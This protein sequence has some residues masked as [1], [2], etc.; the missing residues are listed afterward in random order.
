MVHVLQPKC[1]AAKPC[2][3]IEDQT[4]L[5]ER[6][7]ALFSDESRIKAEP[8]PLFF[9]RD[10]EEIAWAFQEA[11]KHNWRVTLSAG[12]TGIAAGAVPLKSDALLSLEKCLF[13]PSLFCDSEVWIARVPVS[14]TLEGLQSFLDGE[15]KSS[16]DTIPPLWLPVDP[17]ETSA[18]VGGAVAANASGARTFAY[19]SIRPWVVGLSIVLP[20]GRLL[21][22]K[23]GECFAKDWVFGFANAN[24]VV[25]DIRLPQV[26]IPKTKHTLGYETSENMDLIDLF[27]GSEGTLGAIVS[28]DLRLDIMPVARVGITVVAPSEEKALSLVKCARESARALDKADATRKKNWLLA[29][30]EYFDPGILRFLKE[31]RDADGQG[32][33]IPLMP[34]WEGAAV[35]L[36]FHIFS[37]FPDLKEEVLDTM[38]ALVEE[39]SE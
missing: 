16:S 15:Y 21:D 5:A 37:M 34:A 7:A 13:T 24:G 2:E 25:E 11:R 22:I 30:V 33:S 35:W 4:L 14:L 9:P 28:V 20:D 38:D 18:H 3:L 39:F 31:K 23:R 12:R 32:S 36:E 6:Y 19:G 1:I 8:V 26:V 29:S 17:T 27:I 10:A